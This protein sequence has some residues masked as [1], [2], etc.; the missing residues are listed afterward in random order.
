MKALLIS[1]VPEMRELVRVALRSVERRTGEPW[2][3]LEASNGL[4]GIRVAWR[5]LPDVVV[6]DEIASNAG[7]FAVAKD[8]RGAVQ[9]FPGSVIILLARAQD[10][11]LARWSGADAWLMRPVDPFALADAV[12]ASMERR[13][14]DRRTA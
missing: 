9:A 12:V 5:E 8:L 7:A 4:D 10:E 2:E 3:F 13:A 1:P 6:A 11:W 14:A